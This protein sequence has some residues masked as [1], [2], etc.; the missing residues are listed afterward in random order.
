MREAGNKGIIRD[1]ERCRDMGGSVRFNVGPT[2]GSIGGET[3]DFQVSHLSG[4]LFKGVFYSPGSG[5]NRRDKAIIKN[6]SMA[7]W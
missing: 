6:S 4:R 7:G 3:E 5:I 2:V 1:K